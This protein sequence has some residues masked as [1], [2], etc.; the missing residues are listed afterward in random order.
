MPGQV[1]P[2]VKEKGNVIEYEII[3]GTEQCDI[4]KPAVWL[5]ID[6]SDKDSRYY[7][8]DTALIQ[9]ITRATG[10]EFDLKLD[11]LLNND[12]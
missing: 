7:H 6:E 9:M 8:S 4:I 1:P 5:R 3:D 10:K 2:V 11:S 12:R